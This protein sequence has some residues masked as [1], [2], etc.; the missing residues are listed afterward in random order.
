MAVRPNTFD[1]QWRSLDVTL[2]EADENEGIWLASFDIDAIRD[3]RRR[4]TWGD[5]YRKP[6][7]YVGMWTRAKSARPFCGA[8]PG[9][10]WPT[11]QV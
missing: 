8:I 9:V 6:R 11:R 5:A 7:A 2:V 1:E 4:E 10:E 3:Y